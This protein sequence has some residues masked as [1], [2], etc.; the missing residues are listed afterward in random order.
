[1]LAQSQRLLLRTPASLCP[2]RR[3]RRGAGH[4]ALGV[5]HSSVVR[6]F[7]SAASWIVLVTSITPPSHIRTSSWHFCQGECFS[8]KIPSDP[9]RPCSGPYIWLNNANNT[10]LCREE[11]D[12]YAVNFLETA[13]VEDHIWAPHQAL[14]VRN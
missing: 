2:T 13:L 14:R 8:S 11:L 1:M 10:L 5:S 7:S 9:F 4:G 12:W 6:G 3:H